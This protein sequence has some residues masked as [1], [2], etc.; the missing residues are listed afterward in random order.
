MRILVRLCAIAALT[1]AGPAF[2]QTTPQIAPPRTLEEL[3]VETQRRA[4][5]NLYPVLGLKS[6]DA[7]EAL[8][9]VDSLDRDTWAAAG[10]KIGDRCLA[11]AGK[12]QGKAAQ[13]GFLMAWRSY[14]FARWAVPNSPG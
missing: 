12:A 5:H 8:A 4:D 7:Q 13:D 3:K 11:A 9:A 1:L 14:S 2:A 6:A 10:R